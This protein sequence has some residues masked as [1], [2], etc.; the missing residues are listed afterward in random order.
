[1]KTLHIT[2]IVLLSITLLSSSVAYANPDLIAELEAKIAELEAKI[3]ELKEDKQNKNAKI[4]ELRDKLKSKNNQ[5]ENQ[6]A[7]LQAKLDK[8]NAKIAELETALDNKDAKIKHLKE[9]VDRKIANKQEKVGAMKVQMGEMMTEDQENKDTVLQQ[10]LDAGHHQ[11]SFKPTQLTNILGI[12]SEDLPLPPYPRIHMVPFCNGGAISIPK[13]STVEAG[14]TMTFQSHWSCHWYGNSIFEITEPDGDIA[15]VYEHRDGFWSNIVNAYQ[16]EESGVYTWQLVDKADNSTVR[17]SR[18]GHLGYLDG[19]I[20]NEPIPAEHIIQTDS[21]TRYL[22][23]T[24]ITYTHYNERV[25]WN[26]TITVLENMCDSTKFTC[27]DDSNWEN[28]MGGI[29]QWSH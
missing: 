12:Q 13:N 18:A 22:N 29:I 11:N 10:L 7:K 24:V 21:S 26:G 19:K 5:T 4:D 15:I 6:D 2:V 3:N 20:D 17:D 9:K 16:F 14:T 27:I 28:L 1:M 8:K 25:Y 23:G